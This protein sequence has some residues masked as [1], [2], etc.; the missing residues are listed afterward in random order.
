MKFMKIQKEETGQRGRFYVE[1]NNREIA[2][3]TYLKTGAD[4]IIIDHTEVDDSLKGRGVGKDLVAKGV[5]YAREN[6]L[7]IIPQCVF[8][9]AEFEKHADYADVLAV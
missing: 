3:M 2:L 9:K 4:E 5:K 6:D 8:A 7:K 1:E